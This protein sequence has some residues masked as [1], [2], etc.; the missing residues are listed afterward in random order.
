VVTVV[1]AVFLLPVA[2]VCNPGR[3]RE[4]AR[5]GLY[6]IYDNEWWHFDY[7]PDAGMPPTTQEIRNALQAR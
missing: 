7:H 6:R 5:Y 4:L 1:L 3:A 2:F